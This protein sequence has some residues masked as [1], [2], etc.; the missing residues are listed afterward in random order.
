M[1]ATI[2]RPVFF[3]SSVI[4]G[5]IVIVGVVFPD[6]AANLFSAVQGRILDSFGWFYLLAV[7]IFVFTVLFLAMSRYG[8]LKLGPD[9]AEPEYSY[10]SWLA[11]LFAA[12]MG[13]G[14]MF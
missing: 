12:G 2:N 8:R 13:I 11:M 4:I 14:L 1:Q 5:L 9:D 10:I 6:G 3:I 7:G